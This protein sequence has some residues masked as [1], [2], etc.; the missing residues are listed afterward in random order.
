MSLFDDFFGSVKHYD[1]NGE[2]KGRSY[3]GHSLFGER[4]IHEDAHGHK[5]GESY[6]H[7]GI[8]SNR[9]DTYDK[10]GRRASSFHDLFIDDD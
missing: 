5:I 7:Q 1:T 10:N 3:N 9:T 4:I 8:F 6:A 2:F